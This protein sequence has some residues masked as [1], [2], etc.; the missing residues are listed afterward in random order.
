M[1]W[2][3]PICCPVLWE[4]LRR[5]LRGGKGTL[6]LLAY[7][8]ILMA[9][10]L[11]MT[12]LHQA[13]DEPDEWP[14]FGASLWQLFFYAQL[15]AILLLSPGLTAGAMSAE[16]E[17]HTLEALFL[18]PVST[19]SL[20]AGKFFGAV[21]QMLV[22]V[23]SG[24]PVVS[25]V[26]V[27]GGVSPKEVLIGYGLILA[28]GL[29]YA[30]LGFLA[31]CLFHRTPVAVAWAYGFMLI[32][33]IGLPLLTVGLWQVSLG[34]GI[35]DCAWVF[36]INPPLRLLGSEDPLADSLL[37]I[38]SL[39]VWTG[40]ILITCT[41]LVRRVRGTAAFFPRRVSLIVARLNSRKQETAS[42]NAKD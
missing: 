13:G 23:L 21:G 29:C 12:W 14:A 15:A 41:L 36:N 16:R 8:L 42:A 17:S 6:V 3:L 39:L 2:Y 18:T 20:V 24:L 9:L 38:K 37:L 5:R 34:T 4:E 1:T 32:A 19:L 11:G 22:V 31:S 26:F 33:L 7:G 27:Y 40:G 10:L 30:A 28:S 35:Y 25:T